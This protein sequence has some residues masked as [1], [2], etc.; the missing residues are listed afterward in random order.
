MW[1]KIIA[2]IIVGHNCVINHHY[3]PGYLQ[4]EERFKSNQATQGA[5]YTTAGVVLTFLFLPALLTDTVH[6]S[7]ASL[8]G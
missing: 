4:P 7:L 1:L 8:V 2:E 3:P 6:A 5:I